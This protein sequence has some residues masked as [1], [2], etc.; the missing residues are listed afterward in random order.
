MTALQ[1]TSL[2]VLLRAQTAKEGR[3]SPVSSGFHF[4]FSSP[5]RPSRE[6]AQASK[7]Q[8]SLQI[9]SEDIFQE[10]HSQL[11]GGDNRGHSPFNGHFSHCDLARLH[12]DAL[13]M[14]SRFSMTI[15]EK[16]T[17]SSH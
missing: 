14:Q 6:T 16:K 1:H 10:L 2:C 13:V 3:N 5:M 11:Q 8:P 7:S 4:S 12:L 15:L 17:G 9:D